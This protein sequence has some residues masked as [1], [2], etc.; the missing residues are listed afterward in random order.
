MA[1]AVRDGLGVDG[2]AVLDAAI[3]VAHDGNNATE[4]FEK[5]LTSSVAEFDFRNHVNH[6]FRP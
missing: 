6:E 5:G 1:A 2:G 4:L 3:L